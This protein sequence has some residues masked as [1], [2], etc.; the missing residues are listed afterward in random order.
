MYKLCQG[1]S[2]LRVRKLA[3]QKHELQEKLKQSEQA[4]QV[5]SVPFDFD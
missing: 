5:S 2:W 4:R 3:E 1:L